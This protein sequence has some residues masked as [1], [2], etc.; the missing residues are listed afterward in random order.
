MFG[1]IPGIVC[2]RHALEYD[3]LKSP[4]EHEQYDFFLHKQSTRV[5]AFM[6]SSGGLSSISNRLNKRACEVLGNEGSNFM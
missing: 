6:H 5:V 4:D 1:Y 3:I 2:F